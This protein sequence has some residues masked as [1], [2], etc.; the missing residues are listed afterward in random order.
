MGWGTCTC[1]IESGIDGYVFVFKPDGTFVNRFGSQGMAVDQFYV[2]GVIA[3]DSQSN[4]Y[5]SDVHAIK[6][7]DKSGRFLRSVPFPA[8]NRG[9]IAMAFNSAGALYVLANDKK[10]YKLA[11]APAK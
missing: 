11:V 9:A 8:G 2:P 7:F 4:V 6:V 3:V 10:V 5:V 1:L